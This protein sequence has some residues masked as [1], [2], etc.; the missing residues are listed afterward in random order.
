MEVIASI[1]VVIGMLIAVVGG[2]WF[3]LVAFQESILWGLGCLFVPF[4]SL[5]FLVM[6]WDKAAKPFL[7]QLA[8]VVPL[9]LGFAI[10]PSA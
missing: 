1:L 4:V 9:I 2:L 10:S 3:L 5:I 7:V 6:H 8:G